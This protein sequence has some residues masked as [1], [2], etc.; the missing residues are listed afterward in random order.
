M[1]SPFFGRGN[2][3]SGTLSGTPCITWLMSHRAATPSGVVQSQGSVPGQFFPFLD[4]TFCPGQRSKLQC[5]QDQALNEICSSPA[6]VRPAIGFMSHWEGRQLPCQPAMAL[7]RCWPV[8]L[9]RAS[10]LEEEVEIMSL[11]NWLITNF[12]KHTYNTSSTSGLYIIHL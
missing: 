1:L 6:G 2:T 7:L 12:K 11:F 3:G 5:C 8:Y 4:A 9:A 10:N